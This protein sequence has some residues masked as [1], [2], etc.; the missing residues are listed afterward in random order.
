MMVCV[1]LLRP[2]AYA[3]PQA[4]RFHSGFTPAFRPNMRAPDTNQPPTRLY[5]A[6]PVM[7]LP[8]LPNPFG[9]SDDVPASVPSQPVVR[10]PPG[11][12]PYQEA[13]PIDRKTFLTGLAVCFGAPI[14]IETVL[15]G[16]NDFPVSLA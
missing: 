16:L 10:S 9:N 13:P 14:A 15:Y 7:Q 3:A 12:A 5:A 4:A 11:A 6:G 2:A 8:N 1:V